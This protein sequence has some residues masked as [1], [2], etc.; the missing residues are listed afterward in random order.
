MSVANV[1]L[2]SGFMH[3]A[4]GLSVGLTGLAAGYA[5]GVV[6]DVVCFPF[7]IDPP[8]EIYDGAD[9]GSGSSIVHVTVKNICWDGI[10][11]HFRRSPWTLRASLDTCLCCLFE[12]D[13]LTD[14]SLI[15]GLILNTN[16]D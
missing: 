7:P 9:G 4:A 16:T 11:P 8:E 14:T 12:T 13:K 3:L 15:V 6:G 1:A 5:I 2:H 10:D